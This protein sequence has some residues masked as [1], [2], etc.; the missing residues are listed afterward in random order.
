MC[1][2]HCF[3]NAPSNSING[4]SVVD[5]GYDLRLSLARGGTKQ[6]CL[7]L[8]QNVAVGRPRLLIMPL[9]DGLNPKISRTLAA[10][11]DVQALVSSECVS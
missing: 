1:W 4:S 5:N 3:G 6:G 10:M 7:R 2:Y 8:M 11:T 9:T